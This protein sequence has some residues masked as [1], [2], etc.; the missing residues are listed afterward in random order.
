MV[1]DQEETDKKKNIAYGGRPG[2]NRQKEKTT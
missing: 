1:E 2:I